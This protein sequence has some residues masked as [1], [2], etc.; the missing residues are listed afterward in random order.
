MLFPFLIVR[1]LKVKIYLK[2]CHLVL[3]EIKIYVLVFKLKLLIY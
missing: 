2:F 3:N 1:I